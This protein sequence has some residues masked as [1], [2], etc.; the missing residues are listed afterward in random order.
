L[1]ISTET[2][3]NINTLEYI[4]FSVCGGIQVLPPQVAHQRSLKKLN[5][6]NTNLKELPI[7]IGKLNILEVLWL[8][9]PLLNTVPPSIGDLRNL[10]ELN[11]WHCPD[12]KCLPASVAHL[13]QLAKLTL[14]DCA[15]RQLPFKRKRE[16]M[17]TSSNVDSSRD[18]TNVD[19]SRDFT[20]LSS[21]PCLLM[22]RREIA[23]GSFD[24]SVCPNLQHL[25]IE[26]CDE[27]VDVETLPN[28]LI[29]LELNICY[30]LKTL[31]G[32]C[33]LV[34]LKNLHI[35]WCVALEELPSIETL[36]SLEELWVSRCVTLKS[37]KG[38]ASLTKLRILNVSDCYN[39]EELEGIEHCISLEKLNAARC[40]KLDLQLLQEIY[41]N[42]LV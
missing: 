8:E 33:G 5:L 11:I 31:E 35:N 10:K 19:S 7:A 22:D 26:Q 39:L 40:T 1:T 34:K 29:Q 14:W 18:F 27:L 2:L 16:T 20:R 3:G 9:S 12:L 4:D 15:L 28:T 6:D 30:N 21:N 24:E 38:L 25:I 23:Q 13:T 32:L 42:L 37:I 41:K 36:V 17:R